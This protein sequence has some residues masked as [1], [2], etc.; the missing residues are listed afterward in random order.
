M[1]GVY[2]VHGEALHD[3]FVALNCR[4]F[5]SVIY[6]LFAQQA[7]TLGIH[8]FHFVR[9]DMNKCKNNGFEC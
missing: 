2:C 1:T 3:G 9:G 7:M 5:L 4:S 8:A 6:R